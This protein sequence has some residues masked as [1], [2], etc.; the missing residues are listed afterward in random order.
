MKAED[1]LRTAR[2]PSWGALL[3]S[4]VMAELP[5]LLNDLREGQEAEALERLAK[6]WRER[7]TEQIQDRSAEIATDRAAVDARLDARERDAEETR[8]PKRDK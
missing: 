4:F 8:K 1:V 7:R 5:N 6:L 2:S 3:M